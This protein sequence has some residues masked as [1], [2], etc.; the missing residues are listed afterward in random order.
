VNPGYEKFA[1][2]VHHA[3]RE[4]WN[5]WHLVIFFGMVV[6]SF[7]LGFFA[8]WVYQGR[9]KFRRR[10]TYLYHR[11]QGNIGADSRRFDFQAPLAIILPFSNQS[12]LRTATVNLSVSGMYIKTKEPFAENT[13][14]QFVLELPR[15]ERL[16]GT[17]L[18]RWVKP[19]SS[20]EYPAGMGVEF[21]QMS[22]ADKNRIRAYLKQRRWNRTQKR[23]PSP[24][25]S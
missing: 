18:V 17:A 12:T 3:F 19:F 10:L 1:K 24:F 25:R 16:Q 7:S 20:G 4:D 9:K 2:S 6:T 8:S 11:L 22:S 23:L 14:F 15:D 5:P 21:I 13:S